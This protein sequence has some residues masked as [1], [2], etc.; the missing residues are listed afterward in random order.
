MDLYGDLGIRMM[1]TRF[2]PI[3]VLEQ[4]SRGNLTVESPISIK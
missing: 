1:V 3:N 4:D 2:W